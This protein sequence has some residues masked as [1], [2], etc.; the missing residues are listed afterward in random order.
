MLS[1]GTSIYTRLITGMKVKDATAGF[2]IYKRGVLQKMDLNK[3][4]LVGYA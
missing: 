4:E 2:V 1:Y 3:I